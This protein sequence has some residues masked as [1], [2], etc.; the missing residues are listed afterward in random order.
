MEQIVMTYTQAER[1]ARAE[2]ERQ[3]EQAQIKLEEFLSSDIGMLDA[4]DI[5]YYAEITGRTPNQL[6]R[7]HPSNDLTSLLYSFENDDTDN[8]IDFI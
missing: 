5:A 2:R 6:R 1:F 4:V 3:I 7:M 8:I